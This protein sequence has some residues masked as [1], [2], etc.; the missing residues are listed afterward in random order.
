MGYIDPI[1]GPLDGPLYMGSHIHQQGMFPVSEF[2]VKY[3]HD[4]FG[5]KGAKRNAIF[6]SIYEKATTYM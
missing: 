5:K 2:P 3:L 4:N 6:I 1:H